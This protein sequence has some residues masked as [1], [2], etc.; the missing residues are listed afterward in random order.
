MTRSNSDKNSSSGDVLP[1]VI[2]PFS[3]AVFI[4]AS[5]GSIAATLQPLRLSASAILPPIR[6]RPIMSIFL[7]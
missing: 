5:F 6:P 2:Q 3:R 7:T 1:S 4:E